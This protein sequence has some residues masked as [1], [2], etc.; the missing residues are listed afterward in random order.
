MT[1]SE[2]SHYEGFSQEA[3]RSVP[4]DV[5]MRIFSAALSVT[6]EKTRNNLNVPINGSVNFDRANRWNIM[7]P[8]KGW[9]G[10]ICT[11]SEICVSWIKLKKE[12]TTWS[13]L[14]NES[15]RF[16][17]EVGVMGDLLD[18]LITF[19]TSARLGSFY[20]ERLRSLDEY[21]HVEN[22]NYYYQLLTELLHE[23]LI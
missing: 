16:P 8:W 23:L 13:G 11:N 7:Q 12:E 22:N 9:E 21:F 18:Q 14:W 5:S 19:C 1:W 10:W 4:K 2:Q 3:I 17:P 6:R 15:Q 20:S